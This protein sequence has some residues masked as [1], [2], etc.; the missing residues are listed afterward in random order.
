MLYYFIRNCFKLVFQ[1]FLKIQETN[2]GTNCKSRKRKLKSLQFSEHVIKP[3]NHNDALKAI[4][5][6]M[7]LLISK[8]NFKSMQKTER[9]INSGI[10]YASFSE[11]CDPR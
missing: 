7:E 4:T 10:K 8:K 9:N 11:P 2:D 6:E 3:W 5:A 1:S